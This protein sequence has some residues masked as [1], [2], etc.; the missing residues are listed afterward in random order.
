[1]RVS[2]DK[3][4]I[5]WKPLKIINKFFFEKTKTKTK[6]YLLH[7]LKYNETSNIVKY[8]KNNI[9]DFFFFFLNIIFYVP[10]NKGMIA[11]L[12]FLGEFSL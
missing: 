12:S 4:F 3:V 7:L 8:W 9:D 10:Q 1:M 2:N 11:E 5:F 6:L